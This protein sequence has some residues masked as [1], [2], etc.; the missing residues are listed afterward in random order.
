MG[1]INPEDLIIRC[2][3]C[4]T[5][6][7]VPQRRTKDRPIC[8]RCKEP[9]PI[10][11]YHDKPLVIT[12]S[13]FDSEVLSSS[14][15]VLVDCWAPWCGPCRMVAPVL[16]QLASGYAG[17]IKIAKLNVDENPQTSASYAIRSIP[18]ML[19]FK[20]G[21]MISSMVGAQPREEIERRLQSI[22]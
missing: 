17:R 8:G 12:D 22:I 14:V 3:N 21:K 4:G 15:P 11:V 19:F 6:N 5:K 10:G 18:T 16:E 2:S 9:I 7:R 13:T 20:E 1:A